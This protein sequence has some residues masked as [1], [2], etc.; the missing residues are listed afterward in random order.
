M[1]FAAHR[2]S[3]RRTVVLSHHDGFTLIEL[4]VVM[5]LIVVLASIVLV[6]YT[7]TV[8]RSKEAVLKEDLFQ[9]RKAIDEYYADKNK[10]PPSL[11]ALV[12]GKYLRTVPVDPFT[13]SSTTWQERI[14]DPDPGSPSADTGIDDVKSGAEQTALDGTPYAEWE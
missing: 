14:A 8:T 13:N 11:Q 12:D 2:P 6:Q 7:N 1:T 5:M 3:H 4:I 10:Y 9:M